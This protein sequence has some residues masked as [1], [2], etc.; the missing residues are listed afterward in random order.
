MT[1]D[2]PAGKGGMSNIVAS[3][4]FDRRPGE[5][6]L[7]LAWQWN[8]NPDNRFWSLAERPGWLR[9]KNGRV[10]KSVLE[11]QNTLTQRTFG[12]E[13]SG[14]V[15][16][17]VS[18]MKDGDVAG[19]A[20]FQKNYGL[21]GVKMAGGA[22]SVVMV[23]AENGSP[24]EAASVPLTQATVHLKIAMDFRNRADTAS[25]YY[26][27]DG[28]EWHAIGSS[29]KMSYTIPH[30]MGYRFA[31]F[32]YATETAGGSVDFDYFRLDSERN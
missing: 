9:L 11:T 26:S 1:L 18:N 7:P 24:R 27:P 5:P 21:V 25:F 6:P 16:L 32:N 28:K 4:D 8:H 30:F 12:P 10:D 15:C 29:L 3:D 14:S 19:L 13:C 20:A 23:N 22:K 2:I 17:D 31:L